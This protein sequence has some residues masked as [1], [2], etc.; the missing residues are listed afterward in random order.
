MEIVKE[1]WNRLLQVETDYGINVR[2]QMKRWPCACEI[3]ESFIMVLV[4]IL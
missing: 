4:F 2:L 1:K 3:S